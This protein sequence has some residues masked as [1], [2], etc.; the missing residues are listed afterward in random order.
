[1]RIIKPM[2]KIKTVSNSLCVLLLILLIGCNSGINNDDLI[3]EWKIIDF[4]EQKKMLYQVVTYLRRMV[5]FS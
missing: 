2:N 1:M 5:Q 3:G 4:R